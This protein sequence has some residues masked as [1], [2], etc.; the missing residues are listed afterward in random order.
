MQLDYGGLI[1]TFKTF[2][3]TFV[4]RSKG[5]SNIPRSRFDPHF[6]SLYIHEILNQRNVGPS[7]AGWTMWKDVPFS[8]DSG[9]MS[10][11]IPC[12]GTTWRG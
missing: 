11:V 8:A 9:L 4:M 7:G 3:E 10:V 12:T 2:Y 1:S 6:S 5:N